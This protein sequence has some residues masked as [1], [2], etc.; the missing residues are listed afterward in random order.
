MLKIIRKFGFAFFVAIFLVGSLGFQSTA[1]AGSSDDNEPQSCVDIDTSTG[2]GDCADVVQAE[3]HSASRASSKVVSVNGVKLSSKVTVLA[4]IKANGTPKAQQTNCFRIQRDMSIWT[5]YNANGTT[6]WHWKT[7]PKGYRFCK[8]GGKVRD[9][10]CHNMVKIGV[11]KSRAP[12]NAIKGKVK[13]VKVLV[14]KVKAVAKADEKVT[15]RAKAWCNTNSSS[16]YG[17]GKGSAFALAT[18]RASLKGR[19]KTKLIAKVE[20]AAQGDLAAQLSGQSITQIKATVRA[21]AFVKATSQASAKA[22]CTD[23][24]PPPSYDQPDVNV[25]PVACVNPGQTRDVTV[26]VSNPN[27]SADTARLTYR[28]QTTEKSVAANGQVTFTFANQA[29]G[30]YN[31]NVLL[32][33]AVKSA[34]FSV[35]VEACPPPVENPPTIISVE[36]PNDV[37]VN[38]SRTIRVR[39]SVPQGDTAVLS[40]SAQFGT[41]TSGAS[42][43]VS[44]SFDITVTYVAP[45]EVPAGGND[46]VS[47]QLISSNGQKDTKSVTFEI[48]P[49]PVDPL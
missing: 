48:R 40:G 1:V 22:V 45:S 3:S 21:S 33:T 13:L 37:L 11:P 5:S 19:N 6:G 25:T 2:N 35:T 26:T 8:I 14:Y 28:G 49:A 17:E 36:Q 20:A 12:K 34:G 43:S 4:N 23:N 7:Y 24:P 18:G 42:Q 39:G 30:T 9:P 38:N 41:I 32:V 46:T 16:A 27:D 10:L 44:G 15:S 29:Q 47:F 31:G